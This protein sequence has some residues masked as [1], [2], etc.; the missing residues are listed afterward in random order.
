[1]TLSLD[2]TP[3]AA[4][5]HALRNANLAF[6]RRHPGESG[7]RQPVHTLIEGAQHFAADVAARRGAQALAAL[8]R[9]APDAAALGGSLGIADHP[10]LDT[11]AARVRE[12][13][14]REPVEDYRID[15]ED[16]FGPRTD[17]E[18]DRRAL[19]VAEEIARGLR[20]G[21]LPPSLGIRIKPLAEETRGRAVRST[22]CSRRSPARRPSRRGGSSPSPRSP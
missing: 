3:L 4:A 15:F 7:A 19:E 16:G 14:A 1:M 11:V 20:A 5:E 9:W 12:K 22:C 2:P 13:L 17:A 10:A 18:E 6:A 21:T 8:D